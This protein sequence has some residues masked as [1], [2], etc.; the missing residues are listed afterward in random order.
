M[1]GILKVHSCG[2]IDRVILG[3][4]QG[5]VIYGKEKLADGIKY[6][7]CRHNLTSAA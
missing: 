2:G 3:P 5:L 7:I 1:D 4:S 6:W